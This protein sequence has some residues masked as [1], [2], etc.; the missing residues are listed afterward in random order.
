[1]MRSLAPAMSTILFVSGT[2][3]VGQSAS[4]HWLPKDMT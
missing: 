4:Q 3:N 2:N 1:M